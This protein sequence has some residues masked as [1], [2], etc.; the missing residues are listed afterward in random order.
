[1]IDSIIKELNERKNYLENAPLQSIYFGGG[2]PSIIKSV[3]IEKILNAI[4]QNFNI[5]SEI[6]IT[7]ESNPEDLS[8]SKLNELKNIGINR[9]SIGVQSFND[10]ELKML[11]R[12]HNVLEAKSAI[13]NAQE[14][15]FENLSIDLI[16]GIPNQSLITWE[17]N[18]DITFD[19]LIQH[20]SAYELTVEKKTTLH[21]LLKNKKI[22]QLKEK[23][24]LE[25]YKLL[26]E[27]AKKHSFINYEISNFGKENFFSNHNIGYWTNEHYLG[28]GPSAHSFNGKSR[29]WNI[30]SN[31]KY[32]QKI[33][34][35][36]Y[37]FETENL[38]LKQKYNE[39][40]F[41]KLRTIWGVNSKEIQEKF[42]KSVFT[43]FM[44]Q[45]IKW[46]N[47]KYIRK[48]K[49]IFLLTDLGKLF[50]DQI[51]SDLFIIN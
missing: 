12:S 2:T 27:K 7:I 33:K 31:I 16:Y 11:N 50:A 49:E 30:S 39:L 51:A 28:V 43:H 47:K 34:N 26:I 36:T 32:I 8:K 24:I 38:T 6:E 40:I 42:G 19:L 20:F 13:I 48:E 14:I 3:D 4:Y 25:Q 15:G 41:T 46:E 5:N 35:N 18:L 23:K 10:R 9:L 21:Y 37:Y 44:Q 1:M 17:K 22:F 45:I 29:R